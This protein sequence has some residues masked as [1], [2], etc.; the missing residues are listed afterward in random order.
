MLPYV[1]EEH[2]L[3]ATRC[4]LKLAEEGLVNLGAKA[5]PRESYLAVI[6]AIVQELAA[7]EEDEINKQYS[8]STGWV[9]VAEGP[10]EAIVLEWS[11]EFGAMA[12]QVDQVSQKCEDLGLESPGDIG[13][14]YA[15]AS[16][17]CYTS[18]E[19]E[20]DYSF[21]LLCGW[22]RALGKSLEELAAEAP[23]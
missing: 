22:R 20:R 23:A 12:F 3:I 1:P 14:F 17:C 9:L 5:T 13:V 21:Q 8:G 4:K 16:I 15:Q 11:A 19:G 7:I 2:K 18:W 10:E 6:A